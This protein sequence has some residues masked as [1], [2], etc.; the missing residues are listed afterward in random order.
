MGLRFGR[1]GRRQSR[2]WMANARLEDLD[3]GKALDTVSEIGTAVLDRLEVDMPTTAS[4]ELNLSFEVESRKPTAGCMGNRRETP[5][6]V[7]LECPC[8]HA[9]CQSRQSC[10]S[11]CWAVSMNG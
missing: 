1:N 6:P 9:S 11:D 8:E 5:K 7:T 4:F 3:L 2:G 10:R